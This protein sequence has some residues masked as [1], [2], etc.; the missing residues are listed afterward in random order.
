MTPTLILN[1]YKKFDVYYKAEEVFPWLAI[2]LMKPA[3]CR[4]KEDSLREVEDLEAMVVWK[5]ELGMTLM[6]VGIS[7]LL[8]GLKRAGRGVNGWNKDRTKRSNL[9]QAV[10]L[11][12]P[13]KENVIPVF[14]EL[15]RKLKPTNITHEND[16]AHHDAENAEE[17]VLQS[18]IF[19]DKLSPAGPVKVQSQAPDF[20]RRLTK[21][22]RPN[23]VQSTSS[24]MSHS[25]M[26]STIVDT[27]EM[28]LIF[29]CN[30]VTI[31]FTS[32]CISTSLIPC[33]CADSIAL[34]YPDSDV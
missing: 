3:G 18:V 24:H 13:L 9:R 22:S 19:L 34:C 1:A 6:E 7:M 32:S 4:R 26:S 16:A 21:V 8:S 12:E 23:L 28:G 30:Q 25:K 5:R 33:C 20:F 11:R 31:V 2:P 17:D 15:G 29:P 14:E 10:L 27:S